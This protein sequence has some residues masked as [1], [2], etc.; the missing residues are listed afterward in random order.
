MLLFFYR[1]I[2]RVQ[3][4]PGVQVPNGAWV[5]TFQ[6]GSGSWEL[7]HDSVELGGFSESKEV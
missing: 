3:Q 4:V 2:E 6:G 7:Y 5:P 1:L